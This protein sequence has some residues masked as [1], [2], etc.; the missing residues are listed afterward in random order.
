MNL[1]E[2]LVIENVTLKGFLINSG[3]SLF[4]LS[5]NMEAAVNTIP[6]I[7]ISSLT[8]NEVS[9]KRK[10]FPISAILFIDGI[11]KRKLIQSD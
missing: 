1:S 8:L 6:L 9:N 4:M 5:F 2:A 7:S 11:L 3:T 10:S